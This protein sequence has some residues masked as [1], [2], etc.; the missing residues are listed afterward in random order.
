MVED[1]TIVLT[2]AFLQALTTVLACVG[3]ENLDSSL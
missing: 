2:P 3:P 1:A